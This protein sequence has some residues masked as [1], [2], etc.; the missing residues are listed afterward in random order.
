MGLQENLYALRSQNNMTQKDLA[1]QLGVSTGTVAKWE[2]GET[3]PDLNSIIRLSEI[4]QVSMDEL[5]KGY[6]INTTNTSNDDTEHDSTDISP[7]DCTVNASNTL[8]S[9]ETVST[10]DESNDIIRAPRKKRKAP[11]IIIAVVLLLI[12]LGCLYWFVLK[13]I[14]TPFIENE[15]L[16][17][18]A[19]A[20]VVK[21]FCYDDKGEEIATGS[22]FV[23]Y[24]D[25][26]IITNYHVI[27]EAH[28]AKITTSQDI[29][30]NIKSCKQLFE[31]ED[32]AILLTDKPTGLIP[33]T[34]GDSNAIQKGEKV[35]AIGSPLGI[36]NTISDGVLSGRIMDGNMDILQFTAA[37]SSGSS[38]GALFNDQGEVIGVTFASFEEGQNLNLAIPINFV[39]DIYNVNAKGTK[40]PALQNEQTG[41]DSKQE[42]EVY[43]PAHKYA[44][45]KEAV[46]AYP[47]AIE[48]SV[49][50]L[51][52]NPLQYYGKMVR[53]RTRTNSLDTDGGYFF[54][55]EE[56]EC[57]P[58][59][60]FHNW[61]YFKNGN[62]YNYLVK[63]SPAQ[64]YMEP[65][66]AN[67][68]DIVIVGK[69]D[70]F[71]NEVGARR[72]FLFTEVVVLQSDL[73]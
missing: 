4:F 36:K 51:V 61:Y 13:D 65:L 44:N 7:M 63:C 56:G 41:T 62:E 22:G 58:Y 9:V 50:E 5:V 6:P 40:F 33:L 2:S 17:A 45:A 53:C 52:A 67:G 73:K 29:T 3:T 18:E 34:A 59:F 10:E 48:V 69:V 16:I 42:I 57:G 37:I 15:K 72:L 35:L 20:S 28:S 38:G 12:G 70:V 11:V 71:T 27:E 14:I 23:L 39:K 64:S 66:L 8:E 68:D 60:S 26:T 25:S 46:Q 55:S 32:I 1:T 47:D 30:Y 31:E 49:E 24:N 21:I 43:V 19:D 54:V